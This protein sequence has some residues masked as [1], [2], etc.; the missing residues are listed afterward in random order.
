[1]KQNIPTDKSKVKETMLTLCVAFVV[2]HLISSTH[3]VWMLYVAVALGLIGMF[4]DFLAEKI[5]WAW[6]KLAEGIG[7]VMSK[8]IL[9]IVFYVFLLPFALLSRLTGSNNLQLKK[10]GD[11]YYHTR[12]HVYRNNDLE[13]VW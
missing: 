9:S 10:K 13:K 1:M 4:F 6:M 2:W 12:N 11:S 7:W 5:H 3:P 8:V